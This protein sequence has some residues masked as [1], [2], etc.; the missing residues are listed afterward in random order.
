[1]DTDAK[2]RRRPPLGGIPL[3]MINSQLSEKIGWETMAED[4]PV[5]FYTHDPGIKSSLIFIL[6]T[7]QSLAGVEEFFLQ[8]K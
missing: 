2:L 1:M 4:A 8:H 6:K 5:R 3:E 7:R